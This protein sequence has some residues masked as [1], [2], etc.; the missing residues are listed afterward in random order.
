MLSLVEGLDLW[1]FAIRSRLMDASENGFM[2]LF[3]WA[4]N[5]LTNTLRFFLSFMSTDKEIEVAEAATVL[6]A[7]VFTQLHQHHQIHQRKHSNHTGCSSAGCS[8]PA[9]SGLGI[10]PPFSQIIFNLARGIINL[11]FAWIKLLVLV[12]LKLELKRD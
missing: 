10:R 2:Y 4:H 8:Q 7:R 1:P 3:I 6:P 11:C 9:A 5:W 12:E